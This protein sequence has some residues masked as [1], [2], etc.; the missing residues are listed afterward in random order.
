MKRLG[1]GFLALAAMLMLTLPL[2]AQQAP[3]STLTQPRASPHDAINIRAG[4]GRGAPMVTIYYGRP[5][6]KGRQIWGTLVPWNQVWRLGA[7]EATTMITQKDLVFGDVTVP[8]GAYTLCMLPVENGPS[9]L[10]INKAIGQWGIPY[11]ADQQ[12]QELAR[13]DLTKEP[14]LDKPVDELTLSMANASGATT[15]KIS[16]D[17]SV[18]SVSF[19]V[20][21]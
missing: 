9:K 11:T 6:S 3:S 18:Y 16:W 14:D 10:I 21:Q 13:V 17:K 15:L 4:G 12:K 8:A 2:M 1:T 19:K 5:Y 7:D 20:K